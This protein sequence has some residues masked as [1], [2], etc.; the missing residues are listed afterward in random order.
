M[1]IISSK[2]QSPQPERPDDD[3]FLASENQVSYKY[4]TKK[5]KSQAQR[6]EVEALL[7]PEASAAEKSDNQ[8]EEKIRPQRLDEYIGQKDLKEVLNIA[9]SA[10]KSRKESLDHLLLYGPPGLG[11]TTMSLILAAEMEVNCKITTAPAIEKPRDI[12]GLLVGLQKGDILFIDE[13]HRLSKMTEEI[14][15]PAMED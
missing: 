2:K 1:A 11:K 8:N 10:A 5:S 6:S 9:I 14:L 15:Y 3:I 12:V 13:I 7:E 4:K